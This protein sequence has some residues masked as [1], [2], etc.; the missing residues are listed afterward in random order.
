MRCHDD[1]RARADGRRP[2]QASRR[3]TSLRVGARFATSPGHEPRP[4]Q[5]L[6]GG[7]EGRLRGSR[8]M[9]DAATGRPVAHSGLRVRNRRRGGWTNV[10]KWQ[11]FAQEGNRPASARPS[12][13]PRGGRPR[14]AVNEFRPARAASSRS[15]RAKVLRRAEDGH[16][17]RADPRSS[18]VKPLSWSRRDGRNLGDRRRA[19]SDRLQPAS[20]VRDS[21]RKLVYDVD[22]R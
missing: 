15:A 22:E 5:P 14:R 2:V 20:D 4:V 3:P 12:T 6:G 21:R 18:G 16:G 17:D 11:A 7:G 9:R 1:L 13:P 10:S 8:L 19:D